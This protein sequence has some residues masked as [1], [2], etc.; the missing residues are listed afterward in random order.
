M[1]DLR[2]LALATTDADGL[3]VL[4][5]ALTEGCAP[6]PWHAVSNSIDGFWLENAAGDASIPEPADVALMVNALPGLLDRL[7]ALERVALTA[8]HVAVFDQPKDYEHRHAWD[9]LEQMRAALAALDEVP[10]G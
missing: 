5:G 6:G 9:A 7:A 4:L 2:A 10:H 3:R 8:K 1:T